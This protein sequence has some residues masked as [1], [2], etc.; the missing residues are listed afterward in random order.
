MKFNLIVKI[1]CNKKYLDFNI[2]KFLNVTI[3]FFNQIKVDREAS[4]FHFLNN[5]DFT[6]F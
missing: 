4:F 1:R 5:C 3:L 2:L 6:V